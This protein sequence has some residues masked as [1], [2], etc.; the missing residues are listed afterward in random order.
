MSMSLAL[1]GNYVTGQRQFTKRWLC[2]VFILEK[3]NMWRNKMSILYVC[4]QHN[5][6]WNHSGL[7]SLTGL[8]NVTKLFCKMWVK[9]LYWSPDGELIFSEHFHSITDRIFQL[10]IRFWFSRL[11]NRTIDSD[12]KVLNHVFF[13]ACKWPR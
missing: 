9:I 8:Y 6:V 4:M 1:L 7:M 5:P 3:I 12:I 13:N 2:L 10:K 11:L